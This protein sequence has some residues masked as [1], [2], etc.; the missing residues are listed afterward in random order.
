MTIWYYDNSIDHR[1]ALQEPLNRHR[2]CL[3]PNGFISLD[4]PRRPHQNERRNRQ[5]DL[6]GCFEIEG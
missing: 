1:E 3:L 4:H 2:Q 5:A 6:L